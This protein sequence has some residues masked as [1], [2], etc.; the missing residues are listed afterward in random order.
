MAMG[1]E[2]R[3]EHQQILF[4]AEY[5]QASLGLADPLGYGAWA[6]PLKDFYASFNDS[7]TET[8][9]TYMLNGKAFRSPGYGVDL[10]NAVKGERLLGYRM[11]LRA[12]SLELSA[13]KTTVA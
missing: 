2:V 1:G 11:V 6:S 13:D 10:A 3:P 7:V 8:H 4:S 12:V 9:A 5:E